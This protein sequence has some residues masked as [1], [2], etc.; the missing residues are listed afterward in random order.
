MAH[1][2]TCGRLSS[3]RVTWAKKALSGLIPLFDIGKKSAFYEA[4][5][6]GGYKFTPLQILLRNDKIERL[7]KYE[8]LGVDTR[9]TA[10]EICTG[11]D[12]RAYNCLR[13]LLHPLGPETWTEVVAVIRETHPKFGE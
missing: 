2:R 6:Q 11:I 8:A 10:E 1:G 4:G 12:N 9:L 5:A 3:E 13:Y 7:K